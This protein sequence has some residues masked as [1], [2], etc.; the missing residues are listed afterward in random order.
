MVV[1]CPHCEKKHEI[2][3]K[4]I[5]A[6]VKVARC[7]G[8]GKQF[9][10][11]VSQKPAAAPAAPGAAAAVPAA[12]AVSDPSTKQ[13]TRRI[14]VTLSKGGVGK[15]TTSVNLAAGLALAGFKVLLIDTD[16][17]GQD[18]FML[19][20]NP[21]A[22]LTELVT[23]EVRPEEAIIKARERLWLLAGGKSLAGLKRIIDRKDF[24]G[25]MTLKETLEPLDGAYDYVI[26]DT[27]P[28]W[29]PLTV[30][31]LFY[32]KEILAPVSLEVMTLQGLV[33]F[34]KSMSAIQK[35]RKGVSLK[36]ILPTFRD[37]RVKKSTGILERLE[38]LYG[39]I[40]CTPIRYNVRISE[41]PAYGQTIYEYAPGS[42]GA[43]D[44]RELVRKIANNPNLFK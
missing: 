20:V 33:E 28:G 44:Y 10:L 42:P 29:D 40:L 14:G 12:H 3:E 16:T 2:D 26:V 41:A 8:C 35:Y 17:Q 6:N 39:N 34:L 15:T 13:P 36:Y 27:S 37:Q 31:V 38:Q 22:G 11:Q 24:G 30:N 18:S 4:R 19:G 23:Q 43:L 21:K 25:E 5:P 9:P 1:T 32:V 7:N